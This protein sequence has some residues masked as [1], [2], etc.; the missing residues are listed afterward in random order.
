METKQIKLNSPEEVM[1][2]VGT[3]NQCDFDIDIFYN[4]VIIDAK[5]FLGVMSLDISK[6]LNVAYN[7]YNG[8]L[9]NIIS[10]Y[11]VR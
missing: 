2:F 11:A 7:G 8:G 4:R 9:E 5:S 1:D 6:N 10:K 3:A